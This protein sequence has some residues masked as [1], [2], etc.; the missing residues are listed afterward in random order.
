LRKG[1]PAFY[2]PERKGLRD[3]LGKGRSLSSHHQQGE[4]LKA[5]IIN[6]HYQK[7]ILKGGELRLREKKEKVRAR[8]AIRPLVVSKRRESNRQPFASRRKGKGVGEKRKE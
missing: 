2:Y 8:P 4:S 3:V 7:G 5:S 1:E 6:T